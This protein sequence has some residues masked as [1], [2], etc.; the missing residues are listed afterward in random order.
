M[1]I[2]RQICKDIWK[3][4]EMYGN[5]PSTIYVGHHEYAQIMGD[6]QIMDLLNQAP[7]QQHVEIRAGQPHKLYGCDI[8]RVCLD[9]HLNVALS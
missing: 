9:N 2:K 3:F 5:V 6:T 7:S 4:C 1:D 8:I